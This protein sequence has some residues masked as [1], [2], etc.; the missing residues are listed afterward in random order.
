MF[1]PAVAEKIADMDV[2]LFGKSDLKFMEGVY[3][4]SLVTD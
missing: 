2:E 3:K 4:V 1:S